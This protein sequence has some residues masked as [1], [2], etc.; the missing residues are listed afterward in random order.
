MRSLARIARERDAGL[1]LL[2][3]VDKGTSRGDR[4][5]NSEGYSGSTAWNN[6]ARSRLF[7]SR[8][9]DGALLLEHQKY[10]LGRLAQ[11]LRLSWPEGGIPQADEPVNGFVQHIADGTDAK[12]LLKLIHD[13]YGR[14]EFVATDTRS[15][16]HAAKV[17]SHEST[18]P[19]RR[20]PPEV[21]KMLVD[22]E[23]RQLLQREA[24][25]DRNRKQHERWTLTLRDVPTSGS[26]RQVRH[27]RQV[28]MSAHPATRRNR[29][30]QVRHVAYRGCGGMERAQNM[31][32]RSVM[33]A[34]LSGLAHQDRQRIAV[35]PR[36]AR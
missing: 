15:R 7:M 17:L 8:D 6:S 26:L 5:H 3:H 28:P 21:F 12:A 2:A 25:K 10:N 30:R 36:R 11:P 4:G 20:K 22:L 24:Y 35:R 23:R 33:A 29:A 1:L 19:K 16:Y 32:R 34:D 18:Y 9:K 13:F 27:V 31:A 14:G